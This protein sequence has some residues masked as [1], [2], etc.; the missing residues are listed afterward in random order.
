MHPRL[1]AYG[2]RRV[3]PPRHVGLPCATPAASAPQPPTPR[4]PGWRSG[5]DTDGAVG[6]NVPHL[7]HS[8]RR[9]DIAPGC[10]FASE[11]G[12]GKGE[13]TVPS[14]SL[15]FLV[16]S[17][18]KSTYSHRNEHVR[19]LRECR[20][21]VYDISHSNGLR[22][23]I[24]LVTSTPGVVMLCNALLPRYTATFEDF[25]FRRN[26]PVSEAFFQRL[27]IGF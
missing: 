3:R 5:Q 27:P 10:C 4:I 19:V 8:G 1:R 18:S 21:K 6:T 26:P 22:A 14:S 16:S 2:T 20:R 25:H 9:R 15:S 13:G 17:L 24:S 12:N 23:I 7:T 11:T